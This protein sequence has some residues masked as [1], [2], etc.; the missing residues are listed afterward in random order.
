MVVTVFD[1]IKTQLQNT[2][3]EHLLRF[4]PKKWEKIGDVLILKIPKQLYPY[5]QDIGANYAEI[6]HCKSVLNDLGEITGRY[7]EPQTTLIYGSPNTE[8]IHLEN[9]IKYCLDPRHIMFSSGNMAE[10][11]RMA[12]ISHPQETVVDLFAGIGYFTLPIAVYSTPKKIVACEI[13]SRAYTYLNKNISL[14]QVNHI[15]E[16]LLGDNQT[17]SPHN[18]AD[19]VI[20]GYFHNPHNYLLTAFNTL[21]NHQG[22]IHFHALNPIE[23][24]PDYTL[25]LVEKQT[26]H[27]NLKVTLKKH[28]IIKSYAPGIQHIVLDLQVTP[29]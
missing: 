10:R 1:Q 20:I 15:V 24:I 9:N 8:T 14:N 4:L 7:R 18:C 27:H 2:I 28:H 16:P 21:R 17:T 12:T 5:H 19:R 6:L 11:K 22:T 3:P 26:Q 29:Q 13:N 23:T 25:K